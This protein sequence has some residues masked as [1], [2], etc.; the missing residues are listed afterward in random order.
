MTITTQA[1]SRA[2]VL[3]VWLRPLVDYLE[4]TGYDSAAI[5]ALTGVDVR[6]VFVPGARLRLSDAA[7]LWH[8]AAQVTG[9]SFIAWK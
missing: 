7:P 6:Q 9:K 8:H 3:A 4:R 2:T 5:F 1:E